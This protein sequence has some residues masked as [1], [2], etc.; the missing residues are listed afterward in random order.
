MAIRNDLSINWSASPRIITVDAP[1]VEITCQD[2]LDTLR[3]EEAQPANMDDKTIVDASGKETLDDSNNV[4]LTITLQNA[5]VGFEARLGP[6]YIQCRMNG[7]NVVAKTSNLV[8]YFKTPVYPT[9]FT[10]VVTT[11][12]SSATSQNQSSIEYASFEGSVWYDAIDGTAGGDGLQGNSQNPV[13]NIPDAISIQAIRG[14]PKVIRVIGDIVLGTGDNVEDFELIGVSHINSDL[15]INPESE[16]LRTSFTS[17]K[18]SG[19]LDGESE[20]KDCEI[21]N[22]EYFNGHLHDC[23]LS[24]DIKLRGGKQA[25]IGDCRTADMNNHPNIDLGGSGQDLIMP[26][27]SGIATFSNLT[28]DSDVGVGL[29]GGMIIL[30][31]TCVSG[32]IHISGS[33]RVIDNS[34]PDCYVIDTAADGTDINNIKYLIEALRPHHTGTGK[35]YFWNPVSGNDNHDGYHPRRATKT[36][37]QAHTLAADSN[38][39][40]IICLPGKDGQTTE[41]SEHILITKNYLMVRGPGRDFLLKGVDLNVST[42]DITGDGV[43]I[44]GMRVEGQLTSTVPAIKGIGSFP[45]LKDLYIS[46][47]NDCIELLDGAFGQVDNVRCSHNEG[48]GL[49]ITGGT[50][51]SVVKHSHIGSNKGGG[52]IVDLTSGHEVTFEENIIHGNTGYG[53]DISTTTSGVQLLESNTIIGNSLGDVRDLGNGTYDD[54][55]LKGKTR[56]T[57]TRLGLEKGN[58]FTDTSDQ[59]SSQD[60]SITIDITGDGKTTT[61]QTR[62]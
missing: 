35:V 2:L 34:G 52:V 59:F 4:G 28:G 17:F 9:A 6:E 43:E 50:E 21:S 62:Q 33:G 41:T 51:H 47:S 10:Q 30:D 45:L 16:T 48:Y 15:T 55:D 24:G 56:E 54:S 49:K 12:S 13:N 19:T 25:N 3:F 57:H 31:P 26:N 32:V 20:I 39:D 44:S 60:G 1:S 29:N 61:T 37:A 27:F 5:L 23:L 58:P 22:I 8:T 11:A 18:M 36:F 42:V 7:G 38:H 46:D 53:V 40:V 14:L